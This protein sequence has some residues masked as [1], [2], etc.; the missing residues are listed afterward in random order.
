M[1]LHKKLA[2]EASAFKAGR[3]TLRGPSDRDTFVVEPDPDSVGLWRIRIQPTKGPS[4]IIPGLSYPEMNRR[5][6]ELS[7]RGFLGKVDGD[8]G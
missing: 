3:K 5:R 4:E 1:T 2:A 8:A 6:L 7:D